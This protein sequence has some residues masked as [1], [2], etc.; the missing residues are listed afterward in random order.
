MASLAVVICM[1]QESQQASLVGQ[2]EVL[3]LDG[4]EVWLLNMASG[5]LIYTAGP[6]D[7]YGACAICQHYAAKVTVLL[8]MS[9]SNPD[10]MDLFCDII[11]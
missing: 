1:V 6:M 5:S 10:V 8:V 2:K 11:K 3:L 4:P 7:G 9:V